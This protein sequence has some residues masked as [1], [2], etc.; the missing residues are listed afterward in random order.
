MHVPHAVLATTRAARFPSALHAR[1]S[2]RRHRPVR[3]TT[4]AILANCYTQG[5]VLERPCHRQ[6]EAE[7]EAEEEDEDDDEE[8]RLFP[9]RLP[10]ELSAW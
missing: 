2:W 6:E 8:N 7:E 9:V 5:K 1:D 4:T 10:R 3:Q